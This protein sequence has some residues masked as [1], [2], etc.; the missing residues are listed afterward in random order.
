[1]KMENVRMLDE[2]MFFDKMKDF[3]DEQAKA[4]V[5]SAFLMSDVKLFMTKQAETIKK[6]SDELKT[7][8]TEV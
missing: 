5:E 2:E 7:L 4:H 1:M 3:L 6:L 8:K